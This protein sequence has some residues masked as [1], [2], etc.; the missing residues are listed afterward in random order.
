MQAGNCPLLQFLPLKIESH[1]SYD[2]IYINRLAMNAFKRV[3]AMFLIP[4]GCQSWKRRFYEST[5]PSKFALGR[6]F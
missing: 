5:M 1:Y 2:D 4:A 3:I 6:H